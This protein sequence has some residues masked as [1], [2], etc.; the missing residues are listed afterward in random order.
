M[1]APVWSP[2][3]PLAALLVALAGCGAS[4]PSDAPPAPPSPPPATGEQTIGDTRYVSGSADSVGAIPGSADA[5]YYYR[6]RQTEPGS[7]RFVFQDREL[8]FH[9]RP[10]PDVLFFQVE[11]R[12]DR[13]VWIDWDR[14]VFYDPFGSSGK[15]AHGN[16]VW[17]D[18]Y[19]AQPPTQILGLQRY[20]DFV[21]PMDYMLDPG[22]RDE[23]FHR[24]L[25]PED[26]NAPQYS[27]R[28]FGV[29]LVMRVA[30]QP[31]TYTFR[32]KV[33]SVIPTH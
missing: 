28:D 10:T 16:T 12:T 18:R 22:G 6:F 15:V 31:R 14:C 32:F 1:R 27:G 23:Q 25:L 20:G 29:D 26:Q 33:A 19:S 8:S 13:P 24:A 2:L 9:F 11:N 30:D 4:A 17:R 21:Y 3:V 7:D 5:L